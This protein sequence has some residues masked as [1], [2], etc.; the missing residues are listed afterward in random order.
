MADQEAKL[1]HEIHA[2]EDEDPAIHATRRAVLQ[3]AIGMGVAGTLLSTL[4]VGAGLVPKKVVTPENEPL[5]AGDILVY[6]QG[7]NKDKPI[8]P[9]DLKLGGPQTIA[10]PMNP[11]TNV[12]K[13]G[14]PNNTVL[15][16][17]LEPSRLSPATAK[18]AAGGIVAYSG[19]CKH[20]GCIVSNW[21]ASTEDFVCP[22]HQGH[23]DPANGGKVVSGPPPKP[24]PQLPIKVEN[25]QIIATA[26]FVAEPGKEV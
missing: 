20:L 15:V 22:C 7:D 5:A 8:S 25:N 1:E 16:V 3:A 13:G 4:Y 26:F 21:E 11:K 19:V 6:A 12:V 14:D 2:H 23:Y 18:D 17:K 10:Y 24:I 9:A